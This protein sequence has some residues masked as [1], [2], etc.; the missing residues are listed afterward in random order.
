MRFG[1]VTFSCLVLSMFA[2][3]ESR[4]QLFDCV[5]LN[6]ENTNIFSP[7]DSCAFDPDVEWCDCIVSAFSNPVRGQKTGL[8]QAILW[9][10]QEPGIGYQR[11]EIQGGT[12]DFS[13]VAVGDVIGSALGDEL[14]PIG[15]PFVG[16]EFFRVEAKIIVSDVTAEQIDFVIR[17]RRVTSAVET[18]VFY[19]PTDAEHSNGHF[20]TGRMFPRPNGPGLVVEYRYATENFSDDP[21]TFPGLQPSEVS[22][23]QF[24][25]PFLVELFTRESGIYTLPD[26]GSVSVQTKLRSFV[27]AS[28]DEIPPLGTAAPCENL[29]K[30]SSCR[31]FD[32]DL[33]LRANLDEN[34]PPVAK[35]TAIDAAAFALI[36]EPFELQTFCGQAHLLLRG[37]NSHDGDGGFQGLSYEW[38]IDGEKEGVEIPEETRHFKDT[39]AVFTKV[40]EFEITLRVDDGH[41]ENNVDEISIVISVS[42]EFDFNESPTARIESNP[43]PPD[44]ELQDGLAVII[45]DGST[46]DK[47]GDGCPQELTFSWR[48]A[49]DTGNVMFT[50]PTHAVTQAR[51]NAPGVY[52]IELT[53]DDGGT[54]DNTHSETIDVFVTGDG[55]VPQFR[56]GDSDNNGAVNITDAI[57]TLNWLF[58]GNTPA[59][60]C[61][62]AADADD[63]GDTNITDAIFT[64]AFLF[65]GGVVPPDPHHAICGPDPTDDALADCVYRNCDA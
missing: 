2:P 37:R 29:T 46:S 42:D 39:H 28:I 50:S 56:R 58:Q 59:P 55:S 48:D 53:V 31:E 15:F 17:I 14:I 52:S 6:D 62:D 41:A 27:E 23:T 65:S 18:A 10:A 3:G 57:N 35:I 9:V 63:N 40:G 5:E 16:G 60:T 25:V 19:D 11:T 49:E 54:R 43:E 33:D 45:L 1:V 38:S 30:L 64:L 7:P 20:L 24:T 4:A 36:Q 26:E 12:V 32:E 61:L 44:L 22:E 47:G 13:N 21:L 8:R 51:I 34:R